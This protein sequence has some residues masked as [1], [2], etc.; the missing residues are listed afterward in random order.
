VSSVRSLQLVY[1]VLHSLNMNILET[2]L[3]KFLESQAPFLIQQLLNETERKEY[4]QLLA[5]QKRN[6]R[7][8]MRDDWQESILQQ[9]KEIKQAISQMAN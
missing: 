3:L 1:N 9:L 4:K 8:Q 6:E 7:D 2:A 5:D